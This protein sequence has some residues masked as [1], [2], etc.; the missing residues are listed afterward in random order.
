[1]KLTPIFTHAVALDTG[2]PATKFGTEEPRTDEAGVP[3]AHYTV[4][5]LSDE[6]P[7]TE[8]VLAPASARLSV[9]AP[10]KFKNLFARPWTNDGRSGVSYQ[11]AAIEAVSS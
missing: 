4:A 3:L 9:G 2:T 7:A 6:R 10:V 1:V 11:A 5:F 8:R